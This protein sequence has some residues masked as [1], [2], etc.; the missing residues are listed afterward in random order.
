MI[1]SE[2]KQ[3]TVGS[4]AGCD[5]RYTHP[6]ISRAHLKIYFVGESVLIEDLNSRTGTFVLYNG[7]YKRV[8]SAKIRPD[9]MIRV[10][11]SIKAIEVRELILQFEQIRESDKKDVFK[12]VKSVGLRRCSECG[13]VINKTTIYCEC[14]GAVLDESN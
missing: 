5:V 10:G 8:K 1:T 14:C 6:S 2:T 4:S 3:F 12:R 11:D 9:T 13:S 7:E